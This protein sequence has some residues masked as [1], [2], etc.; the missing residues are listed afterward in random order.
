MIGA[1]ISIDGTIL[2]FV[3]FQKKNH[4]VKKSYFQLHT[5]EGSSNEF[6]KH[7]YQLL[8]DCTK[9]AVFIHYMETCAIEFAHGN[10]NKELIRPYKRTCPLVIQSMKD[11]CKSDTPATVYLQHMYVRNAPF[12]MLEPCYAS[13]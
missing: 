11:S 8:T 7:A 5:P 6:V 2:V 12:E 10:A 13:C 4:Q 9:G 1:V 3:H